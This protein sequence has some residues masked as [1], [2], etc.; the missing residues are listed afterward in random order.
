MSGPTSNDVDDRNHVQSHPLT[1]QQMFLPMA[2]HGA[3]HMMGASPHMQHMG[4]QPGPPPA[5][6]G[7]PSMSLA[8]GMMPGIQHNNHLTGMGPPDAVLDQ[9]VSFEC[10]LHLY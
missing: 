6:V 7:P 3:G 2:S 4:F 5:P 8:R 9:Q 10:S 1:Q